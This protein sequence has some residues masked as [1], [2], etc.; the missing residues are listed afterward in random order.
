M[1]LRFLSPCLWAMLALSAVTSA[2][3]DTTPAAGGSAQKYPDA[4]PVPFG[5]GEVL[6]FKVMLGVFTIG[7][8]I[9]EI[10]DIEP[11]R[12]VPSYHLK[13]RI[14]GGVP[15]Y[16]VDTSFQSWIDIQKLVSLR[17]I[18]DQHEGHYTRLREFQFFP[19]QRLWKRAD[20]VE[21]GPLPTSMPLDD[22]SFVYFARAL[23]L[24]VGKQY[25]FERY[26]QETGNPV[27]IR[28][29]RRAETS[30]PAGTFKTIVV[31]PIIR[32][33]GMFSEGGKAELH[34]SDDPRHLLVYLK[35]ELPVIGISMTMA[36]TSLR[37]GKPVHGGSLTW[38]EI[39]ADPRTITPL[40]P[41]AAPSTEVPLDRGR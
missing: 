4:L 41:T 7:E 10:P 8:S 20:K 29:L 19:E 21:Q 32:T 1:L 16:K 15:F 23:P 14:K 40:P 28:V 34:L 27:I 38:A 33:T 26:F 13:W 35:T 22:L 18:Q 24:E 12:G 6:N 11:I 17:F 9:M 36:L 31:Q 3:A 25:R 37:D 2:A 30:V 5:P 39:H